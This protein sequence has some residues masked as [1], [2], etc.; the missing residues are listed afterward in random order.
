MRDEGLLERL[1]VIEELTKTIT[2]TKTSISVNDRELS[3]NNEE[4]TKAER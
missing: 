1:L 2:K 4:N 3:V